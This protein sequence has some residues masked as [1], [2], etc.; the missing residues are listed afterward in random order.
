MDQVSTRLEQ[1]GHVMGRE[2]ARATHNEVPDFRD[3]FAEHAAYVLGLLRRLGV[4]EADVDD[5]AQEVFLIVHRALPGFEGRSRVKT[6]VV[7]ICLRV[8]STYRR[9]IGRHPET[10]LEREREPCIDA[11]Q[12]GAVE[13]AELRT[14]LTRALAQLSEQQRAVIVLFEVEEMPMTEVAKALQCQLFSAYKR[15]YAARRKLK[16]LLAVQGVQP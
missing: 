10:T 3:V 7:G 8:V 9:R 2:S 4:A 6:W 11:T 15:L 16:A 13:Q 12:P 14:S 5:A 1:R